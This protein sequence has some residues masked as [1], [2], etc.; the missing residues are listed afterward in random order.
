MAKFFKV[1]LYNRSVDSGTTDAATADKLTQS[2]QNFL[3]T[4]SAGDIVVAAGV[5]YTV[6]AVD[7]N[8]VL[9]VDGGGVPDATAFTIY[10]GDVYTDRLFN[11]ENIIST[12]R[13]DAYNTLIRYNHAQA[14]FDTLT[15]THKTDVNSDYVV[16]TLN[17]MISDVHS[18]KTYPD[19]VTT[20]NPEV[21]IVTAT[22]S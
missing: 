7:S 13:V 2:G 11:V 9:S 1:R 20:F 21:T 18:G 19:V 17:N 16:N 5:T 15:F 12:Q 10:A 8:T 6:S 3:T 4:V 22:F 14:G